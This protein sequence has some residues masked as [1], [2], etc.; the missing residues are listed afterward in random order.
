ML[1]KLFVKVSIVGECKLLKGHDSVR[2]ERYSVIFGHLLY[3]EYIVYKASDILVSFGSGNG[4][5][6]IQL[7]AWTNVEGMTT[8]SW[9]LEAH[10]LLM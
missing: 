9:W 1:H 3:Q 2:I 7:I 10:L 5:L 8:V 4:L 6:P